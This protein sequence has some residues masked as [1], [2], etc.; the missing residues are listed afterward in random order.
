M[1]TAKPE[2]MTDRLCGAKESV[3]KAQPAHDSQA[4]LQLRKRQ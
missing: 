1:R 2:P 3:F 4:P